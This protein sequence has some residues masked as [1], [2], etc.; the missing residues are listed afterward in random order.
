MIV[1]IL[2]LIFAMIYVFALSSTYYVVKGFLT[3]T[4]NAIQDRWALHCCNF[5]G[6]RFR[7]APGSAPLQKN[8][9]TMYL[10]NHRSWSDFF[11]HDEL[12]DH[13]GS[14]LARLGVAIVFPV[15]YIMSFSMQTVWFFR[16]DA[17]SRTATKEQRD[18]HR[19]KFYAW[20][21]NQFKIAH[22]PG[23][24]VYPEGHRMFDSPKP[25]KLKNGMINYAYSRSVPVQIIMSF[26]N[27][28]V[29]N[30]KRISS[31]YHDNEIVTFNDKPINP[32]DFKSETEFFEAV[33]KRFDEVFLSVYNDHYAKTKKQN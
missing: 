31:K 8:T 17:L 26:G 16:R 32:K 30:E 23:L 22:R 10:V 6:V 7:T 25:G 11:I 21:D 13:C 15:C 33:N 5:F 18:A 14:F 2:K 27:E 28:N 20:I 3:G 12:T 29:I 4:K 24:I 1:R 19:A 9:R